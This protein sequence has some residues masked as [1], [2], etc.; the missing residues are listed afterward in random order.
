LNEFGEKTAR[1]VGGELRSYDIGALQ[2]NMGRK[3]NQ[4]C[5]HCHLEASPECSE[6]MEWPVMESILKTVE[7]HQFRCVDITGGTPELNPHFRSFVTALRKKDCSIQVRTNLTI[8]LDSHMRDLPEF[9]RDN[10]VHLI[11]SLPCYTEENVSAQRGEGVYEKSITAIKRLNRIGYGRRPDLSLD[12]VY[13][14]LGPILPPSQ[15]ALE[16]EYRRELSEGFGISFNHLLTITNMPLGRFRAELIR[17]NQ[18]EMYLQLLEKAFNP[19]TLSE[20]M[21]RHQISVR[22]DGTLYDCDFNLALNMGLK[23]GVPN[24]IKSFSRPALERR[25]IATNRHCF[26]C[27]AGTGS[28]CSGSIL[29]CM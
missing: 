15:T 10:R 26:G 2:V 19:E 9:L 18:E 23:G 3:C 14:P 6:G 13:N 28:S 21:C 11:A 20:L 22:W 17:H 25:R 1:F 24:H 12:L 4:E 8:L 5:L 29:K 7:E 27:T 16:K